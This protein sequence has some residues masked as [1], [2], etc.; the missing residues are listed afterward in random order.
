MYALVVA[1]FCACASA[2]G[3]RYPRRLDDRGWD[4]AAE[5][6]R[7]DHASS[8]EKVFVGTFEELRD[9]LARHE[10]VIRVTKPTIGGVYETL[11]VEAAAYGAEPRPGARPSIRAQTLPP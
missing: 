10:T 7:L 4:S 2:F 8:G 3:D 9:A 6:R 1:Y 5:A 11:V